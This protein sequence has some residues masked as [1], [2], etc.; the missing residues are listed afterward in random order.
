MEIKR[1]FYNFPETKEATN[2]EL[3]T[4]CTGQNKKYKANQF[5]G[6]MPKEV[7]SPKQGKVEKNNNR[8]FLI[9]PNPSSSDVTISM[10]FFDN[11]YYKLQLF[12]MMG[13]ELLENSVEVTENSGIKNIQIANLSNGVYLIV[14]S[15]NDFR[16]TKKL[17]IEHN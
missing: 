9:F 3:L 7:D 2:D 15:N 8:S 10:N 1:D 13:K 14:V 12:D 11:G 17:V 6:L 5:Q 16:I 4:F